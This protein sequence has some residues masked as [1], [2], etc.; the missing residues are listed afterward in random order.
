MAYTITEPAQGVVLITPIGP[1]NAVQV[2]GNLQVLGAIQNL[3]TSATATSAAGVNATITS[4]SGTNTAGRC[5]LQT[6]TASSGPQALV[7]F[8]T[9]YPSVPYVT[10]T[11]GTGSI[12]ASFL[13][14]VA[15][16]NGFTVST[17]VIPNS[18][19]SHQF[20]YTVLA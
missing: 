17:S 14:A 1:G 6:V 13:Y 19:A 12:A 20:A 15:S 9:A 18:N 4:F 5:F 16:T 11:P 10:V 7:I 8:A 2:A 3:G